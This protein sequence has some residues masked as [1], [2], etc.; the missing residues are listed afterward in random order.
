MKKKDKR[1]V[2]KRFKIALL[3]FLLIAI[4]IS[5]FN[6]YQLFKGY[7]EY[8]TGTDTYDVIREQTVK[9]DAEENES[10]IDFAA[11]EQINEDFVG[12][13]TLP[14]TVI[15]YP[16]VKGTDNDYYLNHLIDGTYNSLGT[17]FVDFRNRIP[18]EDKITVIYG[19]SMKNGSMFFLLE[20][21]RNQSF[22]D[23]HKYFIYETKD[24]TYKLEPFA[25]MIMNAEIPFVQFNFNSNDEFIDYLN[26]F[27]SG[28]SFKSDISLSGSDK[29]VMMI[30]CSAAYSSARYVL[31][32]KVSEA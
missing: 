2:D 26:E 32:C 21:Y 17:L 10:R 13:L 19:H 12:W 30:K 6:A 23:E 3:F 7:K 1:S 24:K 25:G 11:L 15:D 28:S 14:D 8:H 4:G 29:V 31:L 9:E 16:V 27:I 20:R 22:Y 5:C 18:F